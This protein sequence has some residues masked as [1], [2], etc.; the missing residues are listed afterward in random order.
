MRAIVTGATGFVGQNIVNELLKQS[1]DVIAVDIN[2]E[3]VPSDWNDKVTCVKM[4][5]FDLVLLKRTL[6]NNL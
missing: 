2:I 5:I 4:N 6:S 3:N 1:I